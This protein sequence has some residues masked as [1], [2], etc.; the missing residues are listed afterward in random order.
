MKR[1]SALLIIREKQIKITIRYQLKRV[2]IAIIKKSTNNKRW[3]GGGE[4][5]TLL[6][7]RWECQFGG[8]HGEHCG[9]CCCCCW[10]AS[11]V[12]DTVRPHRQQ[13]TRLP[14]P[15]DSPGKNTGVGCHF[16]LQCMK[17]KV[18]VKLLS[19]VWPSAT[20]WT[21]AYQVPP[22]MGFSRQEFWSG[23]PSPSPMENTVEAP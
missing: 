18:K 14:H 23:M 7:C 22:S 3:R 19:H 17:W 12:S 5:G 2:R 11:V 16:L 8:H 9:C 13:L 6:L 4:K 21:A 10:V 15:W 20:P 1:C